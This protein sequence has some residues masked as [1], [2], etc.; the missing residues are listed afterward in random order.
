MSRTSKSPI[1]VIKKAHEIGQVLPD[2]SHPK[3]PQK[4]TQSQLFACLVLKAFFQTDYRGLEELLRDLPELGKCI[5][6]TAVPD[7]TTF[8]K[9]EKRL[10]DKESTRQLLEQTF[11]DMLSRTQIERIVELAAIDGSGFESRHVS[12]YF[13]K[14][15][16]HSLA[17]EQEMTYSKYPMAGIVCDCSCHLV[18]A[19][20]TG[21]GPK[22]DIVFA[23]PLLKDAAKI[24]QIETVLGDAAYDSE[25]LHRFA[26]EK[27]GIKTIAPT[28]ERA[29]K[30]LPKG[31]Y[32]RELAEEFPEE[33]YGQRWQVETTFSMIKRRLGPALK[34]RQF[35]SQGREIH[36]KV[37]AHN[38][39]ILWCALNLHKL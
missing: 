30:T 1:A 29:C 37:L 28:R 24:A 17:P 8:Q 16:A 26:R 3:S 35:H 14:R 33:I 36:L 21:R 23:E 13:V 20:K 2:Y 19:V 27:L 11:K 25:P 10:L 7:F 15:K 32:R 5:G 4:F 9:A 38:I 18:L 12:Q 34:A 31:Q 22:S 39:M 6:M